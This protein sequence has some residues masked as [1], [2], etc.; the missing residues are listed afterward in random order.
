MRTPQYDGLPDEYDAFRQLH[1]SYYRIAEAAVASFLGHRPGRCLDLGCGSGCFLRSVLGSGRW[2]AAEA[3]GAA[4]GGW[5]V[6]LGSFIH[7]PL[8][9]F[10]SAFAGFVI[11]EAEELDDD[12]EYPKTL[13]LALSQP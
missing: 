10:F 6:R 2:A 12:A 11:A 1:A 9:E 3:P 8:A 7:L 13:A 4:P 5:R